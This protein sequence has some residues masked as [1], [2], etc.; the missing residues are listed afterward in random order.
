MIR[1]TSG[2]CTYSQNNFHAKAV[3]VGQ[4]ERL[5]SEI[6]VSDDYTECRCREAQNGYDDQ[7]VRLITCRTNAVMIVECIE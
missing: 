2:R 5:Q 7:R 1:N 6:V 3:L 4:E